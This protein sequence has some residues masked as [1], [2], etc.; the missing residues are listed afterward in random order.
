MAVNDTSS[1]SKRLVPGPGD[2]APARLPVFAKV[3]AMAALARGECVILVDEETGTADFVAAAELVT[4]TTIAFM[5][6][7]GRGLTTL[8][9]PAARVE[10]LRLSPMCRGWGI[11]SAPTVSIEARD[12][13]STGI[14]APDRARTIRVAVDPSATAADLISPGH[15]FPLRIDD[16]GARNRG[17]IA[18]GLTRAA[19]Y[20]R[21]AVLCEILDDSG[22]RASGAHLETVAARWSITR[23]TFSES[24]T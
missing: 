15:V 11:V 24:T 3:L 17:A 21:G 7:H 1:D 2:L 6:V 20:G 5:A 12:G 8:A 9:L 23:V 19:G 16:D 13:V 22:E 18:L 10:T 14:S 4:G